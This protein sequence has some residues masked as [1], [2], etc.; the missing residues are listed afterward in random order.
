ML[1]FDLIGLFLLIYYG[2]GSCAP[3]IGSEIEDPAQQLRDLQE[4]LQEEQEKLDTMCDQIAEYLQR[5]NEKEMERHEKEY[6]EQ[7]WVVQRIKDEIV[8]L[9]GTY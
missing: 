4:K 3:I 2:S 7:F 6:N 8:R 5:N 9:G 1:R